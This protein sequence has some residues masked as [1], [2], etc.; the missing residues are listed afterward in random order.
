VALPCHHHFMIDV[1][2]TS[3]DVRPARRGRRWWLGLRFV[4][5]AAWALWAAAGWWTTP[6]QASLAD[7]RAG[8]AAGAVAVYQWGDE[9]DDQANGIAFGWNRQPFLRSSGEPG[10]LFAWRTTT[11]QVRYTNLI[12]DGEGPGVAELTKALTAQAATAGAEFGDVAGGRQQRTVE[13]LLPLLGLSFLLLLLAGPAPVTGT[14]WFWWWV[15]AGMPF[16]L[17]LLAWLTREHPWSRTARPPQGGQRRS[18]FA[19][20]GLAI[21]ASLAG[22]LLTL[23]LNRLFGDA[24]APIERY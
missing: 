18:G 20:L 23:A 6:R 12:T 8:L 9:W 10:P 22:L 21:A 4:L 1:A 19:G 11:G 7:A 14:K 16:G 2:V 5:I 15:V 24:V 3:S 13:V 17:G